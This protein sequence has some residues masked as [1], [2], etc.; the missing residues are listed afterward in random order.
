MEAEISNEVR[1][2]KSKNCQSSGEPKDFQK[3]HGFTYEPM[4]ADS[5]ASHS[6][7]FNREVT[8]TRPGRNRGYRG[9]G[10]KRGHRFLH[11]LHILHFLGFEFEIAVTF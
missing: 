8:K 5:V 4:L 10:G 3:G 6:G 1:F 7:K 2:I 11:F 9:N